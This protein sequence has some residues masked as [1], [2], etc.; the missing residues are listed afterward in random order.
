M[1]KSHAA[2][3]AIALLALA[4]LPA[5]ATAQ[6]QQRKV[7]PGG[8]WVGETRGSA[9]QAQ[10][11]G[12]NPRNGNGSLELSVGG[13]L[14]DWGFFN[15]FSG[16]PL[17]TP[18]WGQLSALTQLTFDWYRVAMQPQGDA[19][20]QAQTPALRLYVRSGSPTSPIFSELVWERYYNLGTPTPT[21]QWVSENT[22]NQLFW[23]FVTGSGYTVG[24]CSNPA[25]VTPGV[26]LKT[27][28]PSTWGN[29]QNCY[30]LGDA[31]VYGIGIGVGSSWPYAYKAYVDNVTL[32]FGG[33]P[34]LA[35]NDNF[36][37]S[38]TATPEP[39]TM[40]LLGSGLAGLGAVGRR[41]RRNTA[42]RE[43]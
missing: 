33:D 6:H 7:Y 24:D 36:E 5:L 26:P 19:P 8:P 32:G 21:N 20:W 30:A 41:R 10:I 3:A 2:R 23:R 14:S 25:T 22:T 34:M 12:N 13:N 4:V 9:G 40:L 35:V 43:R 39:A 38:A 1:T 11:T 16:D 29:G 17:S 42:A 37:L 27:A 31:V 28:S 18:G 15:L